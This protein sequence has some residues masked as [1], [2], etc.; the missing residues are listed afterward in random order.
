MKLRDEP[1]TAPRLTPLI[2]QLLSDI[3]NRHVDAALGML[4]LLVQAAPGPYGRSDLRL[5]HFHLESGNYTEAA[6]RVRDAFPNV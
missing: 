6:R 2:R 5:A 4:G 3:R 1:L